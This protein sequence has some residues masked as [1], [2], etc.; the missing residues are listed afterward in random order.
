MKYTYYCQVPRSEWMKLTDSE[1]D[2]FRQL[3][4]SQ[5]ILANLDNANNTG[6]FAFPEEHKSMFEQH[7][8]VTIEEI[9]T[10][11]AVFN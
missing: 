10:L 9:T 11:P 7:F 1:K 8:D 2:S 5:V 6:H 4:R 3:W